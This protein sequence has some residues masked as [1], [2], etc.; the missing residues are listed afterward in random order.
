MNLATT[1]ITFL[2]VFGGIVWFHEFGH[3]FFAKRAGILVREFSIGMGPK[4]FSRQKNG[5]AYTLRWLP[6]GGYVRMAGWGEDENSLQPGQ[7]VGLVL[8]DAGKVAQINTSSKIQLPN[9]LPV[10]V[11]H[12]DLEKALTISG[13]VAGLGGNVQTYSLE[14]DA[15][16]IEEDGT[17]IRIAPI[18]VQMQS[19]KVWQRI[20][21]NFAGPLNNFILSLV[22]FIFLVFMQGG[23]QYTNTNTIGEV[24]ADSPAAVAGL[25][26]GDAVL[27]VDGEKISSWPDL[28]TIVAKSPE[29][30]LELEVKRENEE[31]AITLTPKAVE[32]NGTTVG[33]MGVYAPLKTDLASKI[34]GGFQLFAD[35][36]LAIFKALGSL[37]TSFSLDKLGGPVMMFQYS[38][39]AAQSGLRTVLALMAILSVN[40]GI[41]NLLPIPALDGGKIVLN[42]L[43]GVRGKPITQEKEGLVTLIGF[44]F[45]FG[46]MILVTWNDIARY[47]FQ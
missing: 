16:I 9:A 20:L 21:V 28:T 19:A 14:H 5:T 37:F 23:V 18:D 6:L 30:A 3:Y 10:E 36:S 38:Q 33:Q 39:E 17:E 40:L 42:I 32:S 26:S 27:S 7:P 1:I 35:N 8:N 31:L 47:F 29:K 12:S 11:T 25:K 44:V 24:V 22:L 2:F 4:I 46:L 13:Y 15:T 34:I 41:M 45:L 43:E